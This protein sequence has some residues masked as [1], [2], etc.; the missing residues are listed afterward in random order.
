MAPHRHGLLMHSRDSWEGGI[1]S[2]CSRKSQSTWTKMEL[3]SGL[4]PHVEGHP[5]WI[6]ALGVKGKPQNFQKTI[7][8]IWANSVPLNQEHLSLKDATV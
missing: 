3:G 1:T 2:K 4:V 5:N 7:Q 6:K 8:K